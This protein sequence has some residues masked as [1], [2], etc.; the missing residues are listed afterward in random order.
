MAPRLLSR[1]KFLP[2]GFRFFQPEINYR[3]PR[4]ASFDVIVRGLI[5]ARAANPVYVK[6]Y[7][8]SLDYNVVADEVDRFNAKVCQAHGW[9]NFITQPT[10][11]TIPKVKP[12]NQPAILQSLKENAAAA[13]ALVAGAKTLIGWLDSGS[14][15]VETQEA[16]R[17]ASICLECSHNN[18]NA[19]GHWFTTPASELIR[20]QVQKMAERSITTIHDEKLNLCDV[21]LCPLR[22]KVHTPLDYILK[23]IPADILTRL[24]SVPK[25]WVVEKSESQS[26]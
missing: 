14:A 23:E 15:P 24:K 21:C 25:C 16:T 12:L 3:A 6:K 17:R 5:Q 4:N 8:W 26:P 13:K 10:A 9:D 22:L 7:S 20:R 11:P 18:Q 1:Q 2:G 19:L